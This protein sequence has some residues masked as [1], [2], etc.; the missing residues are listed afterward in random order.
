MGSIAWWSRSTEGPLQMGLW[1]IEAE[2][3]FGL[4]IV[5][6]PM[7]WADT[8]SDQNVMDRVHTM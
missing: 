6:F 5:L 7:L 3:A 8:R 2:S 1:S 4:A